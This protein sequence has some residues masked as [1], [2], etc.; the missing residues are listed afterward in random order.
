MGATYQFNSDV[1]LLAGVQKAYAPPSPGNQNAEEEEGWNYEFGSRFT[2]QNWNGEAIVFYTDLDNLHGNCTASQGC[3]D[4]NPNDQ[5]NAGNVVIQG[6]EF[7]LQNEFEVAGLK[8]PVGVNY[9]YSDA[10]FKESFS[11]ALDAWGDVESGDEL[12]Y[13]PKTML[14]FEAGIEAD[15]WKLSASIKYF[16]EIRVQAGSE[17]ITQDN[18]VSGHTVVDL[19]ANYTI[20]SKQSLYLVVDNLLD[21]TYVSTKRHGGIQTGK[22]RS[23]QIGYRY[24]F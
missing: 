3:I 21:K 11:S 10:E 7:S 4:D 1:I 22:P 15:S 18:G 9:T 14:Q 5:Y 17:K 6:I 20:D 2:H 16:D 19:S 12:P 23:A 13:L 8:L 24:Q